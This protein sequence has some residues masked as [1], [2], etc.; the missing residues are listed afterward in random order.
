MKSKAWKSI[1]ENTLFSLLKH[2]LIRCRPGS[3]VGEAL[4]SYYSKERSSAVLMGTDLSVSCQ[5]RGEVCFLGEQD[6][7]VIRKHAEHLEEIEL[8]FVFNK[9]LFYVK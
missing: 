7:I 9:D 5:W 4:K 1:E 6:N 2:P 3:S 8:Y